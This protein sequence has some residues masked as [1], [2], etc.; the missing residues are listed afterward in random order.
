MYPKLL[1]YMET[2]KS[3]RVKVKHVRKCLEELS[4]FTF[5]KLSNK[6]GD[7]DETFDTLEAMYE[8]LSL[9]NPKYITNS[10]RYNDQMV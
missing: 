1:Q 4:K 5:P 9:Y 8:F 7:F 6:I 2:W 10:Q 3:S